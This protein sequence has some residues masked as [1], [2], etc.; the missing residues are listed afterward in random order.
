MQTDKEHLSQYYAAKGITKFQP[1]EDIISEVMF[2][3]WANTTIF[4]VLKILTLP[5]SQGIFSS[6]A[7]SVMIG[8][9]LHPTI[10]AINILKQR[11]YL[12]QDNGTGRLRLNLNSVETDPKMDH[13]VLGIVKDDP[14]MDQERSN[15]GSDSDPEM[16][17]SITINNINK[18]NNNKEEETQNEILLINKLKISDES[19]DFL[20]KAVPKV[21][22]ALELVLKDGILKSTRIDLDMIFF[23]PLS[24][25]TLLLE[26]KRQGLS[27]VDFEASCVILQD[28]ICNNKKGQRYKDHAAAIR[29]W[30]IDKLKSQKKIDSDLARSEEYLTQSLLK[31]GRK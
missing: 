17:R 12:V 4:R 13:I 18:N 2:Q 11:G 26:Y 24:L 5:K 20:S 15:N 29:S 14:K 7:I 9:G 8:K 10:K 23:K 27:S 28:Y 16:D 19:K 21:Q 31:Q 22:E 30:V 25:C 1:K 6:R 3:D